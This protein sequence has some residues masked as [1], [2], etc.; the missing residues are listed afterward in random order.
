MGKERLNQIIH[1]INQ[2]KAY[3]LLILLL[4]VLILSTAL[5]SDAEK[6]ELE[7]NYEQQLTDC[8][9]IQTQPYSYQYNI[10]DDLNEE[11]NRP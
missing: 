1:N 8:G 9:C 2:D 3:I 7:Q 11:R 5:A 4:F 10:G 6:Q